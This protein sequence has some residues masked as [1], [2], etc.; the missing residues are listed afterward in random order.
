MEKGLLL[1]G[2]SGR[3][4]LLPPAVEGG[5]GYEVQGDIASS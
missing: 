2:D 4:G 5:E 1:P 3:R